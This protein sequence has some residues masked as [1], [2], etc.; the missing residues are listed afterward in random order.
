MKKRSILAPPIFLAVAFLS[1]IGSDSLAQSGI[2]RGKP[3]LVR[4]GKLYDSEKREFIKDQE[5]LIED[6]VIRNVGKRLVVPK[7][8]TV[9][10]L[11]QH[12]VTPGL[13]DMHTHLLFYQNQTDTGFEDAARPSAKERVER[14]LEFARQDLQAG[15]TTVRDVGNSGQY[16]D[17]RLKELLAADTKIGPDMYASGPIISPPGGQF[18]KLAPADSF[19]ISQEYTEIKGVD[20][21]KAAVLAH[22]QRGVDVIKICANT[23]NKLLTV[24]EI[25]AIVETAH[26]KNIPVTA[27]ATYD[28]PIRNAVLGGVDGIEHGYFVSDSTLDLMAERKV[29]LVPTDVS[30]ERGKIMV[31][32]LG[33]TGKEAEEMLKSLDAFHDRLRRAVEKGVMIVSGSDFYNDV[34]GLERGPSSVDVILSYK[35]AGLPVTDVLSFATHNAAKALNRS[36]SIGNIKK[37]MKANLAVFSGDLENN[38][39]KAL[40]DVEAVFYEGEL[41][42]HKTNK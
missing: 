21:A 39:E 23:D 9:I 10:D 14:G 27:H 24:E 6:G 25:R 16:L 5:I 40:F 12:T 11:S 32:G 22:I 3:A 15:I 18:G 7:G 33:M 38:F 26:A 17:V 35:E 19:L 41:V 4:V 29:Y 37:G 36:D 2:N 1:A 28:E 20:E 42:F 31:A 8:T 13:I 34:E 30:R